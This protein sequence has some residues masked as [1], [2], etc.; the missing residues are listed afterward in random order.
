MRNFFEF[1][2]MCIAE[3]W[4]DSISVSNSWSGLWGP[5]ILWA[6]ASILGYKV[7]LPDALDA[8]AGMFAV[9]SLGATWV[10]TF[11]VRF[12]LSGPKIFAQQEA[13]I[14]VAVDRAKTAE[15]RDRAEIKDK[16]H[17]FYW[18]LSNL[19][20]VRFDKNAP[21]PEFEKY[22]DDVEYFLNN[23]AAW[24]RDNMGAAAQARFLDN[25]GM[26]A[27]FYRGA[28]NKTHSDILLNLNKF[29]ENLSA[30]IESPAWDSQKG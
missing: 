6:I 17:S 22:C 13:R 23:A 9:T 19:L 2:R 27:G 21:L 24:I 29:Q 30:L 18:E 28:Y 26:T 25:S 1:Y 11:V 16:L 20:A 7:K 4:K 10:A 3:A 12:I 5:F 8:Y 15:Q 14:A